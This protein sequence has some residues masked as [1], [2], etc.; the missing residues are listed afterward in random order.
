MC[1]RV[2]QICSINL[3]TC[4]LDRTEYVLCNIPYLYEVPVRDGKKRSG[5]LGFRYK[6][7]GNE[8]TL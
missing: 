5:P 7:F 4:Y 8:L 1:K 3:L 6:Q 2:L